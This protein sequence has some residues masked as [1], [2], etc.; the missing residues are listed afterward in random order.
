[1]E[2]KLFSRSKETGGSDMK[3]HI[4]NLEKKIMCI[5][6]VLLIGT[7]II[8]PNAITFAFADFEEIQA[9]FSEK[10]SDDKLS[11]T[12][13]LIIEQRENQEIESVQL[14]D[15]TKVAKA[16]FKQNEE[17]RVVF[18][19][20]ANENKE[21]EYV[22]EYIETPETATANDAAVPEGQEVVQEN[23]EIKTKTLKFEVSDLKTLDD[24][25]LDITAK[26]IFYKLGEKVDFRKDI[27]ILNEDGEDITSQLSFDITSYNDYK[28][29]IAGSYKIDYN[30]KHPVS[31]QEYAF[32]RKI[33]IE[34]VEKT[35]KAPVNKSATNAKETSANKGG[36]SL[37]DSNATLKVPADFDL[38]DTTQTFFNVTIHYA[39]VNADSGRKLVIDIPEN[40]TINKI[41]TIS[42]FQAVDKI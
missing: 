29:D 10:L 5:S 7:T 26:D 35:V 34:S 31:G 20:T 8:N 39:P 11:S 2:D 30:V 15:G 25:K 27:M 36:I 37:S 6:L 1:M 3:N 42:D 9:K 4:K 18:D 41:P 19:Y 32:S 38:S 23:Q 12:V 33:D 16:D 13:Q 14:P 24:M 21:L 40:Y 17:E 28:A 22:V